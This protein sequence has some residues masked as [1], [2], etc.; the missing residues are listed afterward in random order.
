MGCR[1]TTRP[2]GPRSWKC[3]N[4]SSPDGVSIQAPWCGPLTGVLPWSST[5]RSSYGP[6][7]LRERRTVCQPG[8]HAARRR[9]DVVVAVA[10]VELR[11]FDR[12]VVL[13]AVEDHRAL[14]G[15]AAAVGA[16]RVDVQHAVEPDA[17]VRPRVHEVH[18]PVVVPER[19]GVDPAPGLLHEVQRFPRSARI[20]C[21]GH[22]DAEVRVA[23][24][25]PEVP[26]V[27]TDRR[28][29]EAPCPCCGVS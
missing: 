6:S 10:L 23:D 20:A 29:P 7:T 16:Q 27:M 3:T 5:M 21:A 14:V 24:V 17:A 8:L 26:R 1:C 9:E 12:R 25:D 4:Q 18:L 22:E 11:A 13:A 2:Y 15:H 28:R 19:A